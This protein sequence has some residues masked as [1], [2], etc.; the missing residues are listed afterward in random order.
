MKLNDWM[1]EKGM[2]STQFAA[3]IGCREST[4]SMYLNGKRMPRLNLMRK[5]IEATGG[6]VTADDMFGTR[7][8]PEKGRA[9]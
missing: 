3:L 2:T 6:A 5:I 7:T 9:A 1:A 4:V 8:A